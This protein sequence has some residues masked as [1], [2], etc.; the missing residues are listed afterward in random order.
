M[1]F[2]GSRRDDEW[3]PDHARSSQVIRYEEEA[4]AIFDNVLFQI[5]FYGVGCDF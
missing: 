3:R 1:D 5:H 4:T 2:C